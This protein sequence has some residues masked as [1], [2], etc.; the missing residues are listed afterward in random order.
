MILN[1]DFIFSPKDN[2]LIPNLDLEE[3]YF[4]NTY[5]E[6]ESYPSLFSE[7]NKL[8]FVREGQTNYKT[9]ENVKQSS[10]VDICSLEKVKATF[11]KNSISILDNFEFDPDIEKAGMKFMGKKRKSNNSITNKERLKYRK[12]RKERSDCT[13]RYHNKNS[14]DNIIKKIKSK[15][16]ENILQFINNILNPSNEKKKILKDIDYRYINRLKKDYDLSLLNKS[17]KDLLS[18]DVSPKFKGD[19]KK[20][21]NRKLIEDLMKKDDNKFLIF[22]L[23]IKFKEWLDLFTLKKDIK[24]FSDIFAEELFNNMTRV[25]VMLKDIINK[26]KDDNDYIIS[27]I[28]YLYNYE[29][30]FIMKR[31]QKKKK[32]II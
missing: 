7:N 25:D 13:Q 9:D 24:D 18:F 20:D 22:A 28:F 23:N 27:F 2:S 29:N 4:F 31:T 14:P 17:I 6:N 30:W 21:F 5:N 10:K 26:N 19:I 15:L 11:N 1:S 8:I 32:L 3:C 16:F 12:G